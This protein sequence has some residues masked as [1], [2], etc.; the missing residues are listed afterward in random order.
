MIKKIHQTWKDNDIPYNI[1]SKEWVDSWIKFHPDWEYHLWTDDDNKKFVES[2]YPKFLNLYNSLDCN[3]K[4][5]DVI[6][7]FRLHKDGG[8]YVDLD[9]VCFQSLALLI[10]N[11]DIIFGVE[12]II[13]HKRDDIVKEEKLI[14]N[15]IMYSVPNHSFWD[16]VFEELVKTDLKKQPVVSTGPGLLVR[17]YR[18]YRAIDRSLSFFNTDA[19]IWSDEKKEKKHK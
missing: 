16:A 17:A 12:P 13:N 8:L 2:Y 18:K 11:I 19:F 9:C 7:Y 10:E 5:A 14:S 15:A 4:K 6:R 3:I 1:F